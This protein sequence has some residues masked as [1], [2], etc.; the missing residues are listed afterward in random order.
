MSSANISFCVAREKLKSARAVKGLVR[1]LSAVPDFRMDRRRRHS[2]VTVLAIGVMCMLSCGSSF[3]DME[4]Y[5]RKFQSRLS[6]FIPMANG[7]PSHDTFCRVFS[8]LP[9]KSLV[10]GLGVWLRTGASRTGCTGS[11]T[12]CSAR[13]TAA[14]GAASPRR[15]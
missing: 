1:A 4:A 6:R 5:G 2:L 3:R 14:R 11:S 13:T 7:V 10:Q 9:P 15:T 12:S 8:K